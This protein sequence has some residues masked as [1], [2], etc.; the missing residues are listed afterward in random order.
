MCIRIRLFPMHFLELAS[1]PKLI[2][3][4]PD[5]F[6]VFNKIASRGSYVSAISAIFFIFIVIF[7]MLPTKPITNIINFFN[8]VVLL[9]EDFRTERLTYKQ[10]FSK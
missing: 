6:Y 5:D 1:M 8:L 9:L 10:L 7:S 2:P 4:Y 3:D